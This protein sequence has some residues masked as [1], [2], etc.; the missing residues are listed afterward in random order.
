MTSTYM[1]SVYLDVTEVIMTEQEARQRPTKR[2]ISKCKQLLRDFCIVVDIPQFNTVSQLLA[3]QKSM[4][5]NT[6][7]DTLIEVREGTPSG[8]K[9]K[10]TRDHFRAYYENFMSR[11]ITQAQAAKELGI[12]ISTFGNYVNELIYQH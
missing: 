7:F 11:H 8:R 1:P 3:F 6:D 5:D 10:I 2:D 4:I 12:G 9:R